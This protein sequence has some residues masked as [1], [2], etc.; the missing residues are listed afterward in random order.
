MTK[1]VL[2]VEDEIEL[3]QLVELH[4]QDLGCRVTLAADGDRG[5]RLATSKAFDLIILDLMLPGT[6][7]LEICKQVRRQSIYTPTMMLA[8]SPR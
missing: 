2:V 7:G 4:L 5:L 3:A 1:K 8:V 6:D